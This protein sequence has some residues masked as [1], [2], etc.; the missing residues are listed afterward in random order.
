LNNL[1]EKSDSRVGD[2]HTTLSSFEDE[3]DNKSLSG[4]SEYQYSYGDECRDAQV[5]NQKSKGENNLADVSF[6]SR[7]EGQRELA[8]RGDTQI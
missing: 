6:D 1:L 3:F 8:M 4:E 5:A 2:E 7:S